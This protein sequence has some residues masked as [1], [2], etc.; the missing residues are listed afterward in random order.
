MALRYRLALDDSDFRKDL[1]PLLNLAR[2]VKLELPAILK[3]DQA[4]HVRQY[5]EFAVKLLAEKVETIDEFELG[6]QLGFEYFQGY[7][8]SRPQMVE[9]KRHQASEIAVLKLLARLADHR[10]TIDTL[11]GIVRNDAAFSVKLLRYINSAKFSFRHKIESL[12]QA[13]VLLGLDSVRT[14]AMLAW[15]ASATSRPGDLS[16]DA[17]LRA[18]FCEKLGRLVNGR[19][20]HSFFT[21]GL[22]SAVDVIFEMPMQQILE[23]LPLSDE[24]NNAI[25]NHEGPIGGAVKGAI[26]VAHADWNSVGFGNLSLAWI[27]DAYLA[28][29]ADTNHFWLALAE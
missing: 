24:L 1:V 28:A 4:E 3:P 29:I 15:L 5:R 13:M 10:V 8:L 26:A 21:A 14:L 16:K 25:L 22:L 23:L 6:L 2:I 27:R 9:G 11:E 19:D 7:F 17:V 18:V 20:T 12:R